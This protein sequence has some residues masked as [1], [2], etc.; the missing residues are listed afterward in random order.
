MAGKWRWCGWQG[1]RGYF[2]SNAK[3][4]S[5]FGVTGLMNRK[6][7]LLHPAINFCGQVNLARQPLEFGQLSAL[8]TALKQCDTLLFIFLRKQRQNICVAT[9]RNKVKSATPAASWQ[10][11]SVVDWSMKSL[12]HVLLKSPPVWFQLRL[13][14]H[15]VLELSLLGWWQFKAMTIRALEMI[16]QHLQP[17]STTSHPKATSTL[18]ARA[19]MKLPARPTSPWILFFFFFVS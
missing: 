4:N 11:P 16:K 18:R 14:R 1:G 8:E 19:E 6:S 5:Q 13:C 2:R 17:L 3:R 15:I 7:N 12:I 9:E 10:L